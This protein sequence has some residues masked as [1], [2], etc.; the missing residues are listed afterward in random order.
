MKKNS[1][2]WGRIIN[3]SSVH[4]VVASINKCAYV[5][6][7]HG[8]DGLTKVVALETAADTAITCNAVC[9]GFVYT[10]LVAKQI[11]ARAQQ[12]NMTI[13]QATADLVGEKQPSKR[14]TT[15]EQ[16]GKMVVFLCSEAASNISG[17]EQIMD[18][19]WTVQ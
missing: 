11:E 1:G 4:G 8:L 13:E 19:C 14:F 17:S 16:V 7:K 6:A 15:E 18:G 12:K 10:P 5:A 2:K 3:I 9:P